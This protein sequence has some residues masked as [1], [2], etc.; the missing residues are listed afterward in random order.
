MACRL[1]KHRR[2]PR[3][4]EGSQP[5][6]GMEWMGISPRLATP[7]V[8]W[9]W[10]GGAELFSG[11]CR[12]VTSEVVCQRKSIRLFTTLQRGMNHV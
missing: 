8:G 6:L 11:P 12:G 7:K 10:P 1:G 3:G 9:L 4:G 2:G 5:T